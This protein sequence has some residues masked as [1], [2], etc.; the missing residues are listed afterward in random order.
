MKYEAI[1]FDLDGTLIHTAPEYRY[2]I[3]GNALKDLGTST[4]NEKIDKFWFEKER[5]K[6]IKSE[7]KVEPQEFWVRYNIYEKADLRK[8]FIKVYEDIN[9]IKELKSRGYKLGIVTSAAEHI[10]DLEL[11]LIGKEHF[12]AVVIARISHGVIP[13]P[14]PDGL[15]KC[16]NKLDVSPEKSIY[17]GNAEED[18]ISAKNANLQSVIVLRGEYEFKEINPSFFI[19]SLY[20]LEQI[21]KS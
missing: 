12:D 5:N 13:K 4:S 7:F 3:V 21:L 2:I 17:V 10:A 18:L 15:L 1:I 20:D 9:F 8:N 16:L 11:Q 19:N 6:I 14:H